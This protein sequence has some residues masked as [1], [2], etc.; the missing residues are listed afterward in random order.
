MLRH[1]NAHRVLF[2][3]TLHEPT[4]V[5]TH[6]EQD[7]DSGGRPHK[8][9]PRKPAPPSH[10]NPLLQSCFHSGTTMRPDARDENILGPD[11]PRAITAC[12]EVS[13]ELRALRRI[14]TVEHVALYEFGIGCPVWMAFVHGGFGHSFIALVKTRSR[15]FLHWYFFDFTVSALANPILPAIS[16]MDSS[17]Q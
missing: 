12:P 15:A 6:R 4:V 17:S 8:L 9:V 3:S 1:L 5:D 10:G 11:H 16:S 2:H 13:R 7:H 14:Q